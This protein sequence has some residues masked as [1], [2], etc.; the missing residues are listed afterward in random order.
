MY[1]LCRNIHQQNGIILEK[2]G[3]V[4]SVKYVLL[5]YKKIS[6]PLVTVKLGTFLIKFKRGTKFSVNL[7]KS[8]IVTIGMAYKR[9]YFFS[10]V[11][12]MHPNV[13][14]FFISDLFCI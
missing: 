7:N 2:E 6:M 8:L 1:S 10:Y 5:N 9:S 13:S 14:S 12:C 11:I 3:P 4:P